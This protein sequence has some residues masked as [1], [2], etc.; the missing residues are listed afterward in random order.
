MNPGNPRG[1]WSR[2]EMPHQTARSPAEGS[3]EDPEVTMETGCRA[4]GWLL[5]G[6]LELKGIAWWGKEGLE[7][8]PI[9]G[10]FVGR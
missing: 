1:R 5:E 8:A 9:P 6:D 2:A 7:S 3:L 4:G 10:K